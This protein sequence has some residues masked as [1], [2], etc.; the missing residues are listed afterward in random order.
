MTER[1]NDRFYTPLDKELQE[2]AL[3]DWA[4]FCTL[5]G[6]DAINKAKICILKSRGMSI[7]AMAVKLQLTV[8][9]IRYGKCNCG[10]T[11]K[12]GHAKNPHT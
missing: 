8:P 1:F 9:Q 11:A 3:V 5:I 4:T 12:N 7:Q 6:E 2:I 10:E